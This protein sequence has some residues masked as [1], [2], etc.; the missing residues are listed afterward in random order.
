MISEFAGFSATYHV[1]ETVG[2]HEDPLRAAD[3]PYFSDQPVMR[4]RRAVIY[5]ENLDKFAEFCE[6]E[7]RNK[8]LE[9]QKLMIDILKGL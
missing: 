3:S 2:R 1:S 8:A 6:T 5:N 9:R 4:E 7:A